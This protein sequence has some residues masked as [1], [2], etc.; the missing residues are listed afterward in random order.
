MNALELKQLLDDNN[1]KASYHRLQILKLL[2]RSPD[3]HATA[4]DIYRELSSEIPTLS[5]A[6]IY[7]TL[8][9]FVECGLVNELSFSKGESCYELNRGLHGHM[10]C[11]ACGKIRDVKYGAEKIDEI[12]GFKVKSIDVTYRG[13]CSNCR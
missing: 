13:L 1:I 8:S 9:I 6:T 12:G 4:D 10:V 11:E 3:V 7:N 2:E 5:K